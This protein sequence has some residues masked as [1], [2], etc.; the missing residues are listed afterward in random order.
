MGILILDLQTPIQDLQEVRLLQNL[1][2]LPPEVLVQQEAQEVQEALLVAEEPQE[3]DN[4][5][6]SI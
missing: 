6:N 3:E 4:F 5:T 2:L 1:L